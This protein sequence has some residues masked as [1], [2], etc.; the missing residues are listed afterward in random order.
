M[1]VIKRLNQAFG[2]LTGLQADLQMQ[3]DLA[4]EPIQKEALQSGVSVIGSMRKQ[5]AT[6]INAV[7]SAEP[8]Y[9]REDA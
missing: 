8:E 7:Q 4:T 3:L 5:L 6:R 1:T 9:Q 2:T